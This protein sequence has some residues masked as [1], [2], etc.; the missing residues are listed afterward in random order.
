MPSASDRLLATRL[1][2]AAAGLMAE[3]TYNV[4]VGIQGGECVAVPLAEVAGNRRLV[5]LT[6]PWLDSARLMGT[7][8][9]VDNAELLRLIGS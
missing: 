3:G 1:G 5:P 2:A 8:L 9:G 6:H 7:C 4:L